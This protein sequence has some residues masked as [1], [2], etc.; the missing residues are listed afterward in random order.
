MADLKSYKEIPIGGMITKAG[1]SEE[2]KTGDWKTF[3]PVWDKEKCINC[4][5]CPVLCPEDCIPVEK[6][7]KPNPET[8]KAIGCSIKS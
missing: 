3:A 4:M 6:G 7:E 2:F 1:S 5:I 8:T